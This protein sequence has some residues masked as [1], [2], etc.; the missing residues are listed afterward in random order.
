[1]SAERFARGRC[2]ELIALTIVCSW[3]GMMLVHELGHALHAVVSGGTVERSVWTPFAF[4]RTEVGR[5]PHPALVAWGGFV[6]GVLIPLAMVG[7]AR[8]ARLPHGFLLRFFAGFCLIANGAYLAAGA[9]APVGDT[10]DLV[11]LGTPAWVLA[12]AGTPMVAGGLWMWNGLGRRFGPGGEAP[13]R[14]AL[15]AAA[16]A[17]LALAAMMAAVNLV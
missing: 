1:M 4:S 16:G 13:R 10:E 5:N 17:A 8:L 7:A 9:V 2:V 3:Y 12:A 6:W 14:G 11:R 15:G